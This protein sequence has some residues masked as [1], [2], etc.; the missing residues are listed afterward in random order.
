[1]KITALA[2]GVGGARLAH[3]FSKILKPDDFTIIVNT[4]DDFEHFGLF[5]CPDID[6]VCYT[7]ADQSNPDFG[8]GMK[9]ESFHVLD[10]IKKLGGPDW[11]L[12]GDKDL[13]L[14]L[15]RT[16]LIRSGVSL[17]MVTQQIA[18]KLGVRNTILPMSDQSISTIID[19]VEKGE[20]GFQEYFVRSKCEHIVKG[21]RFSGIDD[22]KP[23]NQVLSALEESDAV[24][25]CPSNPFVSI[26]PIIAL[27]KIRDMLKE[28][29][30]VSVSPIINGKAVKG[31]LSKMLVEMGKSC[32]QQSI[33]DFY[34]DFLDVFY[35]D[36][37]DQGESLEEN[38]SSI[39]IKYS[40]IYLNNI[41]KRKTL[42]DDILMSIKRQTGK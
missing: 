31:P 7:I 2:G 24:V 26:N 4:A 34:K 15:E 12:L 18:R 41:Q 19:T 25:I 10:Q 17:T 11:F 30:V 40:N 3:G 29:F 5:I 22:A 21:F 28:K 39:I 38:Q 23:T 42:A 37:E 35:I 9:N 33:I 6:T 1:M 27:P 20:I 8:W 14:H 36:Q 16:R 32:S 13:A